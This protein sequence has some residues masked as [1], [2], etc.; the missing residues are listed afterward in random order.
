MF[1]TVYQVDAVREGGL[2]G[3]LEDRR[4]LVVGKDGHLG[5][6]TRSFGWLGEDDIEC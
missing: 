4:R 3:C 6:A 5:S 2:K 1:Y